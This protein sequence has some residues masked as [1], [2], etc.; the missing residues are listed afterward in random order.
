MRKADLISIINTQISKENE[1]I[2][3]QKGSMNP[4][5]IEMVNHSKGMIDAYES[6][7]YYAQHK[8]SKLMFSYR[9]ES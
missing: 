2:E 5:S 1:F 4:Q 7:L 3:S 8:D 6:V 9:E